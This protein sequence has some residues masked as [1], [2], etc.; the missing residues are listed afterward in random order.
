[1]NNDETNISNQKGKGKGKG[2]KK[3]DKKTNEKIKENSFEFILNENEEYINNIIQSYDIKKV[4]KKYSK[5]K[6][7]KVI[8]TLIL[9]HKLLEY[10]CCAHGCNITTNWCNKPI[11]LELIRI[12]NQ[13]SDLRIENLKFYCLNCYSQMIDSDKLFL[14]IKKENIIACKKCSFNLNNFSRYFQQL[15][16]CKNCLMKDKNKIND[17]GELNLW[18]DNVN[19]NSLSKI[20]IERFQNSNSDMDS[21]ESI[22]AL[23]L[24]M[25]NTNSSSNNI[26]NTKNNSKYNK[27]KGIDNGNGNGSGNGS[28]SGNGNGSSSGKGIRN[29][30]NSLINI[31]LN[32]LNLDEFNIEEFNYN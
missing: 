27:N 20:D 15:Q 9:K 4:F 17:K 8:L 6:D 7:K 30:N 3:V 25:T 1:M 18:I 23:A 24:L 16:L 31:E 22:N 13:E 28:G 11:K 5:I 10:K 2:N 19:G 12:N 21:K 32:E 14:K 26:Q 29:S